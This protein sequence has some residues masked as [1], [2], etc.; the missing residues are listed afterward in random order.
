MKKLHKTILLYAFISILAVGVVC[1]AI[2]PFS[3]QSH[4]QK[5]I[6]A[7]E[8]NDTDRLR[9]LMRTP[10][11]NLNSKPTPWLF[12]ALTEE[13]SQT[14]LQAACKA[15]NLEIVKIL[16]ENGADV[17]Y[18]H[19]DETRNQGSALTNAAGSLS[20]E[21]FDIIKLLVESGADVRYQTYNGHDALDCAIYASPD[22]TETIQIIE[23]L[24]Q[25]GADINKR[26]TGT[27]DTLLHR[28]CSVDS[29]PVI[30]YLI[31]QRGFDI[32]A[33]NADGDTPLIYFVR[34]ASKRSPDTLQY[35]IENG[36]NL[37]SRNNEGKSAY[38]Y[39]VE[40]H[41]EFVELLM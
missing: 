23:Y 32:N 19:W 12:E 39:A 3:I 21:R 29:F 36:A 26:Y 38:D 6:A 14:P 5:V 8:Q 13:S 10:F 31:E 18:T 1:I 11:K 15:G 34:F 20:S 22:S 33:V 4:T 7:I 24:E 27:Q 30:Q 9:E 28:A 41:P 35:L 2:I 25:K 37:G 16:L 40:R 17:N